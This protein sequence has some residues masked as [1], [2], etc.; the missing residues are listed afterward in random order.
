M[1]KINFASFLC[2]SLTTVI[3]SFP[4]SV[5]GANTQE[6]TLALCQGNQNNELP[7]LLVQLSW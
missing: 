3:F 2:L 7:F 1:K 4:L 5:K 6:E